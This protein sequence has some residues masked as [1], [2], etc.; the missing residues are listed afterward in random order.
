MLKEKHLLSLILWFDLKL[1]YTSKTGAIQT[2]GQTFELKVNNITIW[3][4]ET[5]RKNLRIWEQPWRKWFTVFYTFQTLSFLFIYFWSSGKSASPK[6]FAFFLNI[7]GTNVWNVLEILTIFLQVSRFFCS[8]KFLDYPRTPKIHTST[9]K[10][11]LCA[12]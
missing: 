5:L 12:R 9:Q 4:H 11:F 3:N 6:N 7:L 8:K 1:E 10:I 2:H